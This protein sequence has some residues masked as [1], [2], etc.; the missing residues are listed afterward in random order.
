MTRHI[1]FRSV[2]F[3]ENSPNIFDDQF[4]HRYCSTVSPV[5]LYLIEIIIIKS[6]SNSDDVGLIHPDTSFIITST[7]T[8]QKSDGSEIT[9][10]NIKNYITL[11]YW[12]DSELINYSAIIN[13]SK[14]AI[15]IKPDTIL[16]EW[17]EVSLKIDSHN[18]EVSLTDIAK[19]SVIDIT[20]NIGNCIRFKMDGEEFSSAE[21]VED[22]C[23]NLY[24]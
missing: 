12:A 15:E 6:I 23:C 2:I 13:D 9:N 11:Q 22:C 16:T 4:S 24:N 7:E 14:T 20:V 19:L 21:I 1:E 17:E 18:G 10:E 3:I 8:L 5:I